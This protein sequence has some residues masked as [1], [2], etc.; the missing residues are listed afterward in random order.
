MKVVCN[1]GPLITLSKLSKIN[2]LKE[3][4]GTIIIPEKVRYEIVIQGRGAAGAEEV[5]NASWINVQTVKNKLAVELLRERL[6]AGE[7]EAIVLAM[8]SKADL[9]LMDEARGRRISEGRGIKLIGTLG[10]LAVAKKRG[11]I[12]QIKPLLE[13]LITVG[14]YMSSDLYQAMLE[15]AGE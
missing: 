5:A 7:S 8:E 6:D 11:L 4:Y 15:Q 14:F 2:L 10:L 12:T 9:L 3:L 1:S 13:Q